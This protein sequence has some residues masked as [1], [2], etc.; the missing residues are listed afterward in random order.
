MFSLCLAPERGFFYTLI[1]IGVFCYLV[2]C[3]DINLFWW[4]KL[5]LNRYVFPP[6]LARFYPPTIPT[7][8]TIPIKPLNSP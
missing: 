5:I 4:V 3:Q 7:Y 1:L 8:H 2:L 6:F